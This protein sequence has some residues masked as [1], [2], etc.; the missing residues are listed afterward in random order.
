MPIS[1]GLDVSEESALE[2]PLAVVWDHL[3]FFRDNLTE[4]LSYMTVFLLY[5]YSDYQETNQSSPKESLDI[6]SSTLCVPSLAY[7]NL[8]SATQ[9]YFPSLQDLFGTSDSEDD[10]SVSLK[11][12]K[13]WHPIRLFR[14]IFIFMITTK[15][16]MRGSVLCA[17]VLTT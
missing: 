17:S 3:K 10:H 15:Q 4:W 7:P 13:F 1:S 6:L 14:K 9:L 12:T 5:F 2:L 11:A 16:M 8:H